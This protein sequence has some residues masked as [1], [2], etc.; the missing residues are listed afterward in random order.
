MMRGNGLVTDPF[1]ELVQ[2]TLDE[3]GCVVPL[4]GDERADWVSRRIN[5]W[6]RKREWTLN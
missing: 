2:Y 5:A 6:T 4:R 3:D 1:V